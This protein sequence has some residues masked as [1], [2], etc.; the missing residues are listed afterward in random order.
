MDFGPDRGTA[1]GQG[2]YEPLPPAGLPPLLIAWCT[3]AAKD[4]GGVHAPLRVRFERGEAAVVAAMTELG[5]LARAARSAVLAADAG[6]L[7]RCADASFDA[8]RRMLSLHPRHTELIECARACGVGA[9]YTGSGGAI[10]GVCTDERQRERALE[11][12]ARTGAETIVP[13]VGG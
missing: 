11:A 13:T 3:D 6:A 2:R 10:V 9:N 5:E 4:S 8:R 1:D 12:L 7:A